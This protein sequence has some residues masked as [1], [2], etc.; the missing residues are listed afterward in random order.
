VTTRARTNTRPWHRPLLAVAVGCGV[1]AVLMLP[2]MVLDDRRLFGVSVWLKP[3]KFAVSFAIYALTIAWML[4]L[5]HRGARLARAAGSLIAVMVGVELALIAMQAASGVPSHFND[6]TPFDLLVFQV[7]GGMIMLVWVAN[8]LVAL[9]LLRQRT[10]GPVLSAGLGWG[11]GVGLFAM[12]IGPMMIDPMNEWVQQAAGSYETPLGGGH[13]VGAAD[14]GPGLPVTN[15][16]L[17]AG[18]LRAPHFVGLHALQV[19]PLGALLLSHRATKITVGGKA[20]LVHVAGA[21]YLGLVGLLLWQA[22][23]AEPV[24]RPGVATSVTGGLLLAATVAGTVWI[25]HGA[26]HGSLGSRGNREDAHEP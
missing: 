4:T 10:L 16:S 5:V 25:L 15:W 11:L 3:W 24:T 17:D 14:G 9:V 6:Q 21:T 1:V 19:L 2:A 23:R 20:G 8:L 12:L 7:M 18:D 13:T 26:R 22:L